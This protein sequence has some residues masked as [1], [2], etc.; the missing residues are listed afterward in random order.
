MSSIAILDARRNSKKKKFAID[1]GIWG[2]TANWVQ[3]V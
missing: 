2:A 1:Y 3:M